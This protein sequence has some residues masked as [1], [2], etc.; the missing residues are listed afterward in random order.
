MS[1]NIVVTFFFL[2]RDNSWKEILLFWGMWVWVSVSVRTLLAKEFRIFSKTALGYLTLWDKRTTHFR[3]QEQVISEITFDSPKNC[4][5]DTW[6]LLLLRKHD[7]ESTPPFGRK[8]DPDPIGRHQTIWW[9]DTY[10]VVPHMLGVAPSH[11]ERHEALW[12][13][14]GLASSCIVYLQ[15]TAVILG[16]FSWLPLAK[17]RKLI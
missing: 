17:A 12:K 16:N 5:S 15:K 10:I 2:Q 7:D 1:W 13:A 9:M 14:G 6:H 11:A 3:A 4:L 8:K